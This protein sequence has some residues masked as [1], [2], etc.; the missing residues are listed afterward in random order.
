MRLSRRNQTGKE[1]PLGIMVN[2]EEAAKEA[3]G[4]E[5]QAWLRLRLRRF[6]GNLGVKD[7]E[8]SD[9]AF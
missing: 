3:K 7:L 6:L 4:V 2:P 9:Q 1:I 5:A 8:S